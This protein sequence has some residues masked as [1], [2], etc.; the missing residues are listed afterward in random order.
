MNKAVLFTGS[1]CMIIMG[2]TLP[3][4]NAEVAVGLGLMWIG[5][6]NI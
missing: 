6:A 3:Q 4:L 2:F 1:I 5:L